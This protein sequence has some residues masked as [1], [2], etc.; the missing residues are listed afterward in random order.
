MSASIA[1][2]PAAHSSSIARTCRAGWTAVSVSVATRGASIRV[3]PSQSWRASS[4]LDRDDAR[5]AL[6][7]RPGVVLERER[8]VQIDGRAIRVPYWPPWSHPPRSRPTS[9]SSA[10][11][12]P[13]STRRSSR[14]TR[15][16][17]WCW[18]R[19]TPLAAVGELLGAGRARRGARADDSPELHLAGHASAP[20]AGLV[21]RSAAEVLTTRG[22]RRRARPRAPRR[23]LRRRPLR[24]PRAGARGRASR[25]PRSCTPAA[26]RPAGASRASCR[27]WSP[28]TSAIEVLEDCRARRAAGDRRPLRRPA[29]ARRTARRRARGACSRPAAPPRCGRAR[30]TRRARSAPGCCSPTRA[31]AALADLELVQFHPTAVVG[32]QRRRRLPRHRGGARRGRA[33]ARRRRRALRRRAGAARRGRARDQRSGCDDTG[34]TSVGLDMRAVD[35]ALFPN[36]VAALREAGID[37]VRELVPVAPAAHY[38]M[39]G[40]ATD[41]DGRATL[42]GLYA[43]GECACTGLH[44]ANRLAS[45]S[46]SECFVFGRRAALAALDEPPPGRCARR[47]APPP[48]VPR[49]HPARGEPRGAVAH[50]GIERDAAGL[51]TLLDDPHPLVRL[52]ARVRAGA[53]GEPRRA[54]RARLPRRRPGARRAAHGRARRAR[55]DARALGLTALLP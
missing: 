29:P 27:R 15:A 25:P 38:M 47:R 43:V 21:R 40:I 32:V 50:A 34:A 1:P 49:P 35:P 8:M 26:A 31:G 7:M 52:I 54:P 48:P 33:A 46:L 30:R 24:P 12:P 2:P 6:G 5:G 36:V 10:P 19:A 51:R 11:A 55:S 41:L 20:A 13:A 22:A 37:P 18:S 17:A 39:G 23:A 45:N 9:P 4:R 42:P 44:G 53:R 14:P 16:R 3:I 28:R